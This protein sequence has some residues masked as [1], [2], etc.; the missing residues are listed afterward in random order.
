LV[1]EANEKGGKD[2][3]TVIVGRFEAA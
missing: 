2:N 3:I 1:A